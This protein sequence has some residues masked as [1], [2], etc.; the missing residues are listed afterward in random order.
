MVSVGFLDALEERWHVLS[1]ALQAVGPA[2][3]QCLSIP[4]VHFYGSVEVVL[5][6]ADNREEK[7][8]K[9]SDEGKGVL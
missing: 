5:L 9:L 6:S 4:H 2:A 8:E 1:K 3:L 7:S